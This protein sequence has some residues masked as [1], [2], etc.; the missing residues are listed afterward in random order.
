MKWLN[1]KELESEKYDWIGGGREGLNEFKGKI[2]ED[3]VMID[4]EITLIL[5]NEIG[6]IK[7]R[8][9]G[10]KIN[11]LLDFLK[12]DSRLK[13]FRDKNPNFPLNLKLL[14]KI[15]IF[16]AHGGSF[17]NGKSGREVALIKEDDYGNL[18]GLL[19][20]DSLVKEYEDLFNN[21]H[22]FISNMQIELGYYEDEFDLEVDKD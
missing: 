20:D 3:L 14:N 22:V 5:G 18:E 10:K 1:D 13:K 11:Q 6:E 7:G 8:E 17:I 15:R 21:C 16:A 9:I 4:S 19:F 2:L 12:N